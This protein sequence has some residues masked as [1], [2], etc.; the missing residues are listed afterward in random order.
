MSEQI[1]SSS[2]ESKASA[3]K[4]TKPKASLTVKLLIVPVTLI[5]M[6]ISVVNKM[7]D[8]EALPGEII[9]VCMGGIL[10][11]FLIVA[12][13]QI[14]KVNRNQKSRYQTFLIMQAVVIVLQVRSLL[15]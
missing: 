9:G 10:F 6:Y 7:S 14:S 3:E 13:M 1:V 5:A 2:S 15:G 12:I 8:P 11:G 4:V